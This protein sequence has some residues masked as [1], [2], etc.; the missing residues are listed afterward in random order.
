[1]TDKQNPMLTL[2]GTAFTQAIRKTVATIGGAEKALVNF[3][4]NAAE[5]WYNIDKGGCDVLANF[6]NALSDYP[7]KQNAIMRLLKK[8]VPVTFEADESGEVTATNDVK[9]SAL[10]AEAKAT[11]LAAIEAFKAANFPSLAAAARPNTGAKEPKKLDLN[12]TTVKTQKAVEKV[13][14]KAIAD[15]V[16]RESALNALVIWVESEIKKLQPVEQAA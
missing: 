9:L 10:E 13:L 6:V 1:M 2:S 4:A 15:G 5:R 3:V 7:T 16:D 14:A 12:A 8:F 11:Y